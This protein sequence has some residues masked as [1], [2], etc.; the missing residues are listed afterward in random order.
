MYRPQFPNSPNFLS[1]H[2]HNVHSKRNPSLQPL[3][4]IVCILDFLFLIVYNRKID[5]IRS[6]QGCVYHIE[7]IKE[8]SFEE[9]E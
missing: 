3:L 8:E 9:N 4:K 5:S 1:Y 2:R 7:I 6:P